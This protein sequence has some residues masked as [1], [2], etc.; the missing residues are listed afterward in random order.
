M[1]CPG[2]VGLDK[3]GFGGVGWFLLALV[4][5]SSDRLGVLAIETFSRT[6]FGSV[7]QGFFTRCES[8]VCVLCCHWA[9]PVPNSVYINFQA[10]PVLF[11]LFFISHNRFYPSFV[12][13]SSSTNDIEHVICSS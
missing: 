11:H 10:P 7:G 3:D 6:T 9:G 4:V 2:L 13:H 12:P 8:I 5:L 1:L